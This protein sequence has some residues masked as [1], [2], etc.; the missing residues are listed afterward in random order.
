MNLRKYRYNK[1]NHDPIKVHLTH[2]FGLIYIKQIINAIIQ[3]IGE[4]LLILYSQECRCVAIVKADRH[5]NIVVNI[6]LTI[7]KQIFHLL[8][9]F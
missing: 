6:V 7:C 2:F 9:I 1:I 3:N 5:K 4:Y 8:E